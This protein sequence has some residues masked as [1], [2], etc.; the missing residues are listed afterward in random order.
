MGFGIPDAIRIVWDVAALDAS[1]NPTAV[2][3]VSQH[4]SSPHI[5]SR[6]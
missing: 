2:F 6:L 3:T 4:P 1:G 5:S